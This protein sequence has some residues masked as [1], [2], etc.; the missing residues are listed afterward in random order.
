LNAFDM[1]CVAHQSCGL[2]QHPRDSSHEYNT[3]KYW[4]EFAQTLERGL[5]DGVFLADVT[6]VYDV[7]GGSPDA[8]LR[9]ALQVPTND[10]FT[11]VP[12]MAA[13][14]DHLCFG[15]TGTIPYEP[16][17]A[18]A[19]R[20]SSLDHITAGR[21]GWNVVTGYLDSAARG[22]GKK[23]Q[24]EHDTRY[25]IA[26]EYI[27]L[28]YKLW[29]GSWDDGAVL[30]DKERGI[31]TDPEKVHKIVHEGEYFQ[32]E[33]VHL[34]EPS[35]QRTPVIFQAGASAK[36]QAFAGRHA[37]CVFVGNPG[38]EPLTAAV[39][40]LRE[41]AE[42]QGRQG[43]DLKIFAMNSIVVAETDAQA[44][45]KFDDYMQYASAEAALV[46]TSGWTGIDLSQYALTDRAQATSTQAIQS[47]LAMLGTRTVGE[48]AKT[49]AV[50]GASPVVIGSPETVADKLQQQFEETGVDGF[51]LAY[52]VMPESIVDFVEMVV[53]ELQK[54]G[55]Y[56]T[57][58]RP[59]TFREKLFDR[60]P[61]LQTP[62]PGA[63]FRN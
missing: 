46:L 23:Q 12:A 37:E 63:G 22:T 51:N 27:E 57:D 45:A 25:E 62:H 40:R 8:A 1:N 48:W 54:R 55:I 42:S 5:F 47:S 43:A 9:T 15:V 3:M 34:C 14:T 24:T 50:G 31:F 7:Y 30:R 60:G 20:I 2:W 39:N 16:P 58:Y 53:P 17:Y 19:R 61:R 35:P 49:L 36:G 33:A 38:I 28:V 11:I 6:G 32:L 18:F 56:K 13:V 21:M 26:A 41:Q 10:P 4:L 52:T 44:Q 59:G 29:E